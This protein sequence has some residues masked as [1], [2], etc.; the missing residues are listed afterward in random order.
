MR[1]W[2]GLRLWLGWERACCAGWQKLTSLAHQELVE[3]AHCFQAGALSGLVRVL[4]QNP[5][6]AHQLPHPFEVLFWL[7]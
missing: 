6:H 4:A 5:Q 2:V 3:M 7:W 1:E